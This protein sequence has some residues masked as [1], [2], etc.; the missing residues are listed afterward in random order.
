MRR[1]QANGKLL[2]HKKGV[3]ENEHDTRLDFFLVRLDHAARIQSPVLLPG[4]R[5]AAP[6][7]ADRTMKFPRT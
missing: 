5:P 2:N 3:Q 4:N 1:C 6:A 7:E